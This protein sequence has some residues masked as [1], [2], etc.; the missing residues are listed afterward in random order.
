MSTKTQMIEDL[1]GLTAYW[2]SSEVE[3]IS[4]PDS[5]ESPGAKFL[6]AVRDS[7]VETLEYK[8]END[9]DG[10]L[11]HAARVLRDD[12]HELADGAVPIYT[13]ERWQVFVDLCAY[14]VDIDDY[15]SGTTDMTELAGV[16]L[17]EVARRLTDALCAKVEEEYDPFEQD[18]NEDDTLDSD[19]GE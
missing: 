8:I 12:A 11:L 3:S 13:H 5:P 18:D 7:V 19:P 17:Y 16:A 15:A 4:G 1:K 9:T 6:D 14:N 2:L 10:D